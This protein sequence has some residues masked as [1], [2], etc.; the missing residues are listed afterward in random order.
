[1]LAERAEL[2]ALQL[3]ASSHSG[4]Y[5]ERLH[6]HPEAV[7]IPAEQFADGLVRVAEAEGDVAG[8][9]VLLPPRDGAC[10]LDG[11]FV[12]PSRMGAGVGRVLIE[13]AAVIARGWGAKRIEVVAN[14]DAL[15]F[16]SRLG[17]TGDQE[18]PTRFGPGVRMRLQVAP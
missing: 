4:A 8:F 18:V 9:A 14:P 1:V 3:R 2:E 13:D 15:A 10:E 12:E 11:I 17:F 6:A 16:Y 5:A 7:S